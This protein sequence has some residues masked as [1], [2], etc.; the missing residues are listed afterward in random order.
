MYGQ[1]DETVCGVCSVSSSSEA[2][3]ALSWLCTLSCLC[4]TSPDDLKHDDF[5]RLVSCCLFMTKLFTLHRLC[6]Q[7]CL[8]SYR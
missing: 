7:L 4:Y 2:L 1:M 5:A 6:W 8:E 3:T